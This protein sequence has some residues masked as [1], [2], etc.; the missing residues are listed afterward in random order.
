M[1]HKNW[2]KEQT[3]VAL[4]IYCKIPFNKIG[5]FGNFDPELK[6]RG[7]VGLSNTS[8]LDKEVWNEYSQDWERLAFEGEQLIYKFEG[9]DIEKEI[10]EFDF[11]NKEGEYKI[12]KVKTRVNQNFFRQ[13]VYLLIIIL[14]ELQV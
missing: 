9:K 5:N 12:R 13:A 8:K 11:L 4:I 3:I 7:I 10:K 6:K 1:K 2:T 14:V